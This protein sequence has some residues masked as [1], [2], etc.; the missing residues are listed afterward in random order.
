NASQAERGQ[1]TAV[2]RGLLAGATMTLLL[3]GVSLLVGVL[4]QLRERRRALAIL[5]AFGARRG[6]LALSI[7]WQTAVPVALGLLVAVG[8]GVMVGVVLSKIV[9]EPVSV[10]WS[11]IGAVTAVAAFVVLAVTP[12][13]L[14]VLRRHTLSDAPRTEHPQ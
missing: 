8:S 14:P 1:F 9:N 5:V 10:D 2:R 3:I 4:E 7:L 6:T 11:S 12:W 13:S